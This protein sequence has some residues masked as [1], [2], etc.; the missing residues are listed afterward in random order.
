MTSIE[1]IEEIE[2]AGH[3]VEIVRKKIK[4]LHV[5]VYPPH[6]RIR[7]AAPLSISL[8]AVK[9]AVSTRLSWIRR[10]QV[11]FERQ[12]RESPRK[13]VS[14][15]T[16]YVFG[17]PYRLSV[18]QSDGRAK[19]E[20]GPGNR[21]IL[22]VSANATWK[23]KERRIANWQREQLRER[24]PARVQDWATHLD[25]E[26]PSWRIKRM[27]TL[28]GSC[29]PEKGLIWINLELSKKPL[30]CLDYIVLHEMAHLISPRHD[31]LFI[32]ILDRLMPNWR[33]LRSD[34]NK[35]PLRNENSYTL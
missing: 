10:K 8:E 29:N 7:V 26:T 25:V 23:E 35:L 13:F 6:G 5:G 17:K 24:L 11:E 2:V 3:P 14:G 31:D 15:E 16:H 19:V 9:L 33:Q 18:R 12:D 32:S 1:R 21:L 20:L 28:W 30:A 34:L 22:T 4:N 27:K